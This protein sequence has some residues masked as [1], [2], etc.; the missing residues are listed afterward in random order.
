M[1][2]CD[3]L[4]YVMSLDIPLLDQLSITKYWC[5]ELVVWRQALLCT[6]AGDKLHVCGAELTAAHQSEA[7]ESCK[8][9]YL[10]LHGNG[11]HR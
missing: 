2:C 11:T 9:S 10:T 1:L 3:V 6:S 7:L 8:T 5:G 4:W